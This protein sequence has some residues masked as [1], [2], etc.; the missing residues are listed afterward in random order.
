[1]EALFRTTPVGVDVVAR[2]RLATRSYREALSFY[3]QTASVGGLTV[4]N[5]LPGSNAR[6]DVVVVAV[7]AEGGTAGARAAVADGILRVDGRAVSSLGAL[8]SVLAASAV[9]DHVLLVDSAG[10]QRTLRLSLRGKPE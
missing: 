2:Y 5:A 7:D 4:A 8:E 10:G 1:M 9:A 6:A 3:D